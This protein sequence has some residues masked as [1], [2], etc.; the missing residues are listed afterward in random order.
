MIRLRTVMLAVSAVAASSCNQSQQSTPQR[1]IEVRGAEQNGLH[2]LDAFNL[3]I[4]LKRAIF[5]L[6]YKCQRVE[7]AGFV[8]KY[9]NLD[10]WTAHCNDGRDWAIFAGPDG[11]AQ[12]RDCKDLSG[13][14]VPKCTVRKV[15]KGSFDKAS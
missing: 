2:S 13:G 3:S 5:D 12:V 1:K 8:G 6:G 15:P 9:Q 14:D 11:S 4:A 7:R 10:M